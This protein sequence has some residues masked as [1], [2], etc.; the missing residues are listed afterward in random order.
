MRRRLLQVLAVIVLLLIAAVLVAVFTIDGIAKRHA[1][2]AATATLGVDTSIDSL[3]LGLLKG[4]VTL[5]GLD[6]NNPRGFT[7]D[8]FLE[9][10]DGQLMVSVGSLMQDKIVAPRLELSGL[11]INLEKRGGKANYEVITDYM[12]KQDEQNKDA[13]PGKK[14][15]I[16]DVVIRN[17]NIHASLLPLVGKLTEVDLRIPEIHVKNVGSAGDNGVAM[18]EV[19]NLLMKSL[20]TAIAQK[21]A[22]ALPAEM[23]A[24]LDAQLSKLKEVPVEI[25]GDVT[26]QAGTRVEGVVGELGKGLGDLGNGTAG[27]GGLD[28]IGEGAGKVGKDVTE[29][30]GKALEGIGKG[31]F[32]EKKSGQTQPAP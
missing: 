26:K 14:Y 10:K 25:I 28:K 11:Q 9:M 17:V 29:G 5:Q 32:G 30:A 16:N 20:L 15:V 12:K 1:E 7:A 3:S 2:S 27:N 13:Q 21:T 22:G 23:L 24:D 6:V 18:Q 4:A 8:H 19:T 31:I